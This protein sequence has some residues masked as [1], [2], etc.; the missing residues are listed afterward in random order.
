MAERRQL[1]PRLKSLEIELASLR[2]QLGLLPSG[3]L[4]KG[5]LTIEEAACCCGV[6]LA[7]FNANAA[8][9]SLEPRNFTGEEALRES[10]P[11]PGEP[12]EPATADGS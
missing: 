12:W 7:Q 6:G 10:S 3:L 11:L 9:Y 8:C 2:F 1:I 5:R 4:G